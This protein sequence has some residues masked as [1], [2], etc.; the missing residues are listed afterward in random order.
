MALQMLGTMVL[1][2]G[3]YSFN[4]GSGKLPGGVVCYFGILPTRADSR[5]SSAAL[6]ITTPHTG[7]VGAIAAINSSLSASAGAVSGLFANLYY[8]ER[9]TGEY[10]FDLACAMN[11]A[12]GAL[13][14]IV[15]S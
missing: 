13:V 1:W 8:Q 11:G 14:A 15:S 9:K 10:N 7:E 3:W 4:G 5:L 2:F 6:L 12:L